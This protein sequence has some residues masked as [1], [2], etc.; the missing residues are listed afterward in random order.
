M[1]FGPLR[2]RMGLWNVPRT[3]ADSRWLEGAFGQNCL[4]P[5]VKRPRLCGKRI[6][7]PDETT[8]IRLWLLTATRPTRTPATG[9]VVCVIA[10]LLFVGATVCCICHGFW[11]VAESPHPVIAL[12]DALQQ[13]SRRW[14]VYL[15]SSSPILSGGDK[16]VGLDQF[17]G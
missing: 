8:M 5:P 6:A 2:T 11:S 13:R 12:G 3:S 10:C 16:H 1:F 9:G 17:R 4:Q 15:K 7:L 14:V